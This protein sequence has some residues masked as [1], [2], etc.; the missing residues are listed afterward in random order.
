[1]VITDEETLNSLWL[2]FIVLLPTILLKLIFAICASWCISKYEF[3]GKTILLTIID[4]PFSIS[5]VVIG[6]TLILVFG[7]NSIIGKI[8]DDLGIQ[9]IFNLPGLIIATIF[10]TLPFIA[11]KMIIIMRMQSKSEEE[12]ALILGA[13]E[14]KI[15]LQ[16]T[17]P[18]IKWAMIHGILLCFARAVGEFGA[19]SIVSGHI[20]GL[21]NTAPLHIE[22]LYNEYNPI[23]AF[24]VASIL[25]ILSVVILILKNI[26]EHKYIKKDA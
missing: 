8:L 3:F 2:T 25:A 19:V 15:F 23:A 26:I 13:S 12:A 17:L 4:L 20:R 9:I 24:I 6:F 10:V 7:K 21:T 16:I 22:I 14:I 11:K 1:E 5:P 18:K